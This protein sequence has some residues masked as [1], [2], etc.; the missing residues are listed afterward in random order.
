MKK[1]DLYAS[2][3]ILVCMF[4]YLQSSTSFAS[5][6]KYNPSKVVYDVSS[7]DPL[8]LGNILDRISMLQNVY[9]NNSFDASII[10]VIHEKA[11]PLFKNSAQNE[12]M[13][14]ARSLA[15]GDIIKFEVCEASARMQK[16]SASQLHDFISMI[17]MADAEIIRLQQSGYAYLR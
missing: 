6:F 9:N 7:E 3:Y 12:L 1:R 17:P 15:M 8:A 11:I 14:R 10:V 13:L 16:I 2:I 5:Q 4:L